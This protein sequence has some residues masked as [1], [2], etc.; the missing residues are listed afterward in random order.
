MHVDLILFLVQMDFFAIHLKLMQQVI[1][2]KRL[3]ER[4]SYGSE[5]TKKPFNFTI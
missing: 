2:I 3:S 5:V 1:Q 4:P